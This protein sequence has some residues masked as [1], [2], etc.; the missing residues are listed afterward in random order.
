MMLKLHLSV[1]RKSLSHLIIL[2]LRSI[3]ATAETNTFFKKSF[4]YTILS[5]TQSHAGTLNDLEGFVRKMPGA[6]K[7]QKP[8]KFTDIDEMHLKC[9]YND[10]KLVK[11]VREPALFTFALDKPSG[12]QIFKE[13][14]IKLFF[15]H[16]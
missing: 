9:E 2:D 8:I 1:E 13:H 3:L 10:G 6:Y 11:G 4:L 7:G 15:K 12:H 14:I 16:K 5:F